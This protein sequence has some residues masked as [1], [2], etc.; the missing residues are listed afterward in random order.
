M[1]YQ[2]TPQYGAPNQTT[3]SANQP[4][5]QPF[6]EAS[7]QP[8]PMNVQTST[9]VQVNISTT[10]SNT[11]PQVGEISGGGDKFVRN[12]YAP[13]IAN[14][15][16]VGAMGL[17]IF[18]LASGIDKIQC[19]EQLGK[20]K[21]L[22]FPAGVNVIYVPIFLIF[23]IAMWIDRCSNCANFGKGSASFFRY[24][25]TIWSIV[26]IVSGGLGIGMSVSA[27]C[28]D[29][30]GS[31]IGLIVI[32]SLTLLTGICSLVGVGASLDDDNTA[33]YNVFILQWLVL[34]ALLLVGVCI[35]LVHSN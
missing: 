17:G 20:F 25:T 29:N 27:N 1:Y 2:P 8:A 23:L 19:S 18:I 28:N 12:L 14:M 26:M 16:T 34:V 4:V 11:K 33:W 9:D 24:T 5:P 32:S 13:L 7:T 35:L 22:Y 15:I 30:T 10:T 3:P 21:A 31:F 6:T